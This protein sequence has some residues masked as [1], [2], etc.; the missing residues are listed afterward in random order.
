MPGPAVDAGGDKF[1]FPRLVTLHQ[2]VEVPSSVEH[3][4]LPGQLAQQAEQEAGEGHQSQAWLQLGEEE[5]NG[6]ILHPGDQ[7]SAPVLYTVVHQEAVEAEILR[8]A[9]GGCD[10]FRQVEDG[11]HHEVQTKRAVGVGQSQQEH[12]AQAV[13]S[14]TANIV[15]SHIL[16]MTIPT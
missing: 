5:V 13:G 1:V 3:G 2:V 12:Q 7:H 11:E 9:E 8:I 15:R 10:V 14:H 4:K 6:E 16:T